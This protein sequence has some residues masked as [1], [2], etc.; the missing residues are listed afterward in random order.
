MTQPEDIKQAIENGLPGARVSVT[1]DGR[2]FQA[3]IVANEFTGKSTLQRH[4]MVY[5]A[6]GSKMRDEEIHA[7]T[8]RTLTPD[9]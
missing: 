4:Q 6:L 7:L 5:R 3:E 1:G 2:H 9:E 8:L